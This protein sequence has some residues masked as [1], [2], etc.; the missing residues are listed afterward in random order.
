MEHLEGE[1]LA[2]RLQ[3]GALPAADVLQ[4]GVQISDALDKA[5]RQGL[6]HRD[7]KPG[8]VMLTKTGAKLL[9]FGLARPVNS[10]PVEAA[11]SRTP[12]MSQ[13]L[14][15]Q[16]SI[17]GTFQYMAPETLEGH[18]AD[19]RSDIF[20]LGAV[21][22]EMATGKKAFEGKSQA[23]LIAAI[24]EREPAPIA[25]IAPLA[26]PALDRLVRGCLAKDPDERIQTA[27]DVRLQLQW[28]A[29]GGSL[30]GVPAPVAARRRSRER[31]AWAMFG[32]A[33]LAT[34][35]LAAALWLRR[36]APPRV[37]RFEVNPPPGTTNVGWPRLSPDGRLLAFFA[38]D[39]AGAQRIWIRPIDALEAHPLAGTENAG[40]PFWS[41]DGRFLAYISD[42]KLR[43]IPV[44]G[45]PAVTIAEAP[46]GSDGAWGS[47]DVILFD[48]GPSDSIMT[49]SATGGV[50]K[51]AT[52]LD[53]RRGETLNAWPCFLPDGRHFL[54][55]ASTAAV[56]NLIKVGTLGSWETVELGPCDGRVE[57]APPG[58]L[59]F[60]R[61]GTP[62]AQPFDARAL[63]TRGDPV[64]IGESV[65]VGSVAGNFS[66]SSEGTL[67]YRPERAE[68]TSE[69][70][71][72]DRSG[73]SLGAAGPP[74]QY[75]DLTLSLDGTRVAVCIVDTRSNH[76]DIWVRQFARGVTS[77]LTFEK[78]DEVWPV[79]SPDGSRVA[80]AATP[81]T[82][83]RTFTKPASGVGGEDSLGHVLGGPEG[84]TDW[85]RDG[86]WIVTARRAGPTL[87]DIWVHAT[88]GGSKPEPLIQTPFSERNARLSPDGRWLAYS[89]NE[90]GRN[91]I[92]VQAFPVPG[93]KWQVSNGGGT[94]PQWRGDGKELFYRAL[95]QSITAVPVT[96]GATFEVGTPV[97]LFK[98]P[99][100]EVGYL[101][102]RWAVTEDGQRFLLNVPVGGG[103]GAR[104]AI[105]GNW[106]EE[107]KKKR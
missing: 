17:V 12:T 56:P 85:S 30:A 76:E 64:P 16:G 18:E 60:S 52:R 79:W 78:N 99:L 45:G 13:P 74:A 72:V 24:L 32:A 29:E 59:V 81:A 15:A 67:A 2:A 10:G 22:Y 68:A 71:W 103:S 27:H 58:Y 25:S 28:L 39:S 47:R 23:S 77:R 63:K 33:A 4:F 107:L 73:R 92:Y 62:L 96:T 43:K 97:A 100:V 104:F 88:G 101:G 7:L 102:Y 35:S 49:V 46:G 82:E 40:R 51:P 57:Y 6:I 70:T 48:G 91:E 87:W 95:D 38:T 94:Q 31:V 55:V 3:R 34:V 36:P 42:G 61:E 90:S 41:P 65:A 106:T 50:A 84:P 98:T 89:S 75:R 53:R 21:L 105:V 19:A 9:D 37:V 8:N 69:L 66:V 1:T 80:Y 14:T 86:R 20:A 83:F 54:F 93:G 11:L 5:H 26:P 44:A